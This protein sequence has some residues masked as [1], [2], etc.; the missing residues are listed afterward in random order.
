[1][2]FL[3]QFMDRG[4]GCVPLQFAI[5]GAIFVAFEVLVDGTVGLTAGLPGTWRR[6]LRLRSGHG[7]AGRLA[8]ER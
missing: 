7:C 5:L 6:R 1:V 4:L 3:A 8:L 2:A